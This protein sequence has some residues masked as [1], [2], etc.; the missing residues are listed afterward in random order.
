MRK[1]IGAVAMLGALGALSACAS[2][3]ASGF[4]N[5]NAPNEFAVT[6]SPPLVIPPD[7]ALR[8]PRP[9][10]PRPQE[11]TAAS[12]ALTAMFGGKAAVSP[13]QQGLVDA[14]GGAPDTGIRSEAGSPATSVVDKG[15]DTKS[16]LAAPAGNA[17]NT[18]VSTPQ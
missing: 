7:F 14:A 16:I 3:K 5:R 1:T 6:R 13:G 8:P 18:T 11:Q 4:G 12:E 10:A 9:G 17:Q 15:A 2:S